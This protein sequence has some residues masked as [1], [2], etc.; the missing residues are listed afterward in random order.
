MTVRNATI[1]VGPDSVMNAYGIYSNAKENLI[2][3]VTVNAKYSIAVNLNNSLG[4]TTI[5]GGKFITENKAESWN[6]NPTIRYQG[7]LSISEALITRVGVGIQ[8][9]TLNTTEVTGLT[10]EGCQ[11]TIVNGGEEYA[12][13]AH[14]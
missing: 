4:K 14:K 7:E 11:F 2:E 3:N 8:C 6:P 13:T 10:M 1:N 12:D 9:A 5:N